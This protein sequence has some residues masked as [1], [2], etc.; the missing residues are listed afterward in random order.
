VIANILVDTLK[1][2]DMKYPQP[3]EGLDKIVIDG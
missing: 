3:A 1:G 2:L